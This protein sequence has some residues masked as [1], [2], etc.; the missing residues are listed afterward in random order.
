MTTNI[1]KFSIV[2]STLR[3]GEQFSGARF[4]TS[5]KIKIAK[6]LDAFGVEY[7]ETSSPASSPISKEDHKIL[8][9]LGL[10]AKLVPHL[11]CDK[12]DI[13]LALETGVKYVNM[14]FATSPILQQYSHGKDIDF[15]T[16]RAVEMTAYLKEQNVEVRFSGEDAFRSNREDLEKVF[17][18]VVGC[19]CGPNRSS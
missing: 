10:K 9:D 17:K 18:R 19:R 13:D 6:L 16:N 1:K 8:L 14:M 5:N 15:I 4:T 2:D 12:K 11:R 3:E 7:I